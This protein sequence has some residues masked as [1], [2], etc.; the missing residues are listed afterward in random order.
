MLERVST[1]QYIFRTEFS[2][3][4]WDSSLKELE[5][6]L[7]LK[8]TQEQMEHF[9]MPGN[10]PQFRVTVDNAP[11]ESLPGI[12]EDYFETLCQK[13][14]RMA[15]TWFNN[16]D[17]KR[18]G[19]RRLV[20]QYEEQGI[21]DEGFFE[22]RG[23]FFLDLFQFANERVW[24]RVEGELTKKLRN[25]EIQVLRTNDSPSIA[26]NQEKL[27]MVV[28]RTYQIGVNLFNAQLTIEGKRSILVFASKPKS[29]E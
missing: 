11:I 22:V 23:S 10:S 16:G 18:V 6:D 7:D 28:T 12:R 21:R 1:E 3:F 2:N 4:G 25:A 24:E 20:K 14:D 19:I 26:F 15:Q 27:T 9:L 17:F 13:L 8:I 5:H 29:V